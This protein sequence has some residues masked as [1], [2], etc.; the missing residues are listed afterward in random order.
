MTGDE[1]NLRFLCDEMLVRLGR[2]LRAA[3]YDTLIQEGGSDRSMLYAAV[4]E[5]RL[6]VTRDRKLQEFRGAAGRVLLL[7]SNT[8][9]GCVEE[10]SRR[11]QLNW[12]HRP[13]TRCLLCNTLLVDAEGSAWEQIPE[14]THT[15][16][17]GLSRCEDCGRLYW[18]GG[19]VRRMRARL[20]GWQQR[21]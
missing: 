5:D 13:F 18:E 12:L 7:E 8:L 19:H 17:R 11:L 21:R 3:G 6:L 15:Y 14:D 1:P 20:A 4:R 2:W 9:P 16:A 10:L